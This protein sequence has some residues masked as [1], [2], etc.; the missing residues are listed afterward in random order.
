MPPRPARY[1]AYT[2]RPRPEGRA[3]SHRRGYDRRWE[4]YRAAFLADNPWCLH[5]LLAGDSTPA[6]DVDHVRPANGQADPLFWD[7]ANHQ[8]LCHRC[9]SR[10][11][12]REDGGFGRR[13][14]ERPATITD[15]GGG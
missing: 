11:T 5:C 8:P 9:H 10:K 7:T 12:A 4:Q 1:K 2:P 3:N 6:T 14:T 13:A 15:P